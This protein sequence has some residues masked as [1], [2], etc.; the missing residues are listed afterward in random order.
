MVPVQRVGIVTR[1]QFLNL[2]A[3]EFGPRILRTLATHANSPYYKGT[4]AKVE[5]ILPHNMDL[6]VAHR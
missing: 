2:S 4:I 6:Q 1:P 5:R 3:L